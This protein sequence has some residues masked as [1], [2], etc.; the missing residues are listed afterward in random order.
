MDGISERSPSL[1]DLEAIV[2]SL[3]LSRMRRTPETRPDVQTSGCPYDGKTRHFRGGRN[4]RVSGVAAHCAGI[5]AEP[6]RRSGS[7]HRVPAGDVGKRNRDC[8]QNPDATICRTTQDDSWPA[9]CGP[10][11]F[12]NA[13]CC[14]LPRSCRRR[15]LAGRP[16]IL[17]A[18]R[19]SIARGRLLSKEPHM[20]AARHWQGIRSLAAHRHR[21][22]TRSRQIAYIRDRGS[23][24]RI[25]SHRDRVCIH[26]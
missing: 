17:M 25:R 8:L 5:H 4:S 14:P 6:H 21:V 13:G 15:C 1:F 16:G 3:P 22:V 9:L 7:C 24:K 18:P 23:P 10:R 20:P 19:K 2:R 11:E 12:A 26:S